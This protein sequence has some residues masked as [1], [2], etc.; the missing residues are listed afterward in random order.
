[1]NQANFDEAREA[2][3]S[4]HSK[5]YNENEILEPGTWMSKPIPIVMEMLDRLLQHKDHINVLD[6]GCGAGRNAIPLALRLK[7]TKSKVVGVDL[8]EEAINKLRDNAKEYEV[9]EIIHVEKGDV[10]HSAISKNDYD[11]IL[12]C[13]CL[14]HVSSEEAFVEVLKRMKLAT[15]IG[16]IHCIAMNTN[17]QEVAQESGRELNALIELNL[18]TEKA[19]AMLEKVYEGWNVLDQKRVLLSIE[20]E[21]YDTPSEFRSHSITFVV[22]RTS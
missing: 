20:E 19:F 4:Y 15:R 8:L 18:P 22:Q 12:A 5:L 3:E 7:G 1:M 11:Y 16:G 13:G 6:L 10:E 14:E 2:E 21:K 9:S 17:V